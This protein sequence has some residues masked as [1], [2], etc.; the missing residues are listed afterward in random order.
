MILNTTLIL[1]NHSS[2]VLGAHG[3]DPQMPVLGWEIPYPTVV[4][5]LASRFT[6]LFLENSMT[7][8]LTPNA[9]VRLRFW[10]LVQYA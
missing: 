10:L 8:S 7:E 4:N 6:P 1:D 2:F 9:R 5:W 3:S